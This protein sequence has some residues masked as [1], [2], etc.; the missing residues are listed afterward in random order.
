[1]TDKI[2]LPEVIKHSAT[3]F[4]EAHPVECWLASEREYV[5]AFGA[6]LYAWTFGAGKGDFGY[7]SGDADKKHQILVKW[8]D[9][10]YDFYGFD[11]WEDPGD[12]DHFIY[13]EEKTNEL[14]AFIR[15]YAEL[16]LKKRIFIDW[17]RKSR[18][19]AKVIMKSAIFPMD[20]S[21]DLTAD[22]SR[23]ETN[24]DS[25]YRTMAI[26]LYETMERFLFPGD[27]TT[28]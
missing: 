5:Q 21:E 26:T 16:K 14:M 17:L 7:Y 1:M 3:T 2:K 8:I 20:D 24:L 13:D 25:M 28:H 23:T 12:V 27:K 4:V 9:A 22:G 6:F 11:E 10:E 15:E 19:I 18:H